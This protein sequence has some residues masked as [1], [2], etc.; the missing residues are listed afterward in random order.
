MARGT[1]TTVTSAIQAIRAIKPRLVEVKKK[2]D[3]MGYSCRNLRVEAQAGEGPVFMFWNN[4]DLTVVVDFLR[5][6]L[7]FNRKGNPVRTVNLRPGQA[8]GPLRVNTTLRPGTYEY[9]VFMRE[10]FIEAEGGSRPG[11]EIVP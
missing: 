11:I 3:G 5:D 1:R 8:S 7:V 2:S 6:R 10:A 4:T 9:Q